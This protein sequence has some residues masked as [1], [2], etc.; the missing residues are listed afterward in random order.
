[1]KAIL[2]ERPGPKEVLIRVKVGAI[3]GSDAYIY[4]WRPI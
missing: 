1:M 2:K 4:E 3:C